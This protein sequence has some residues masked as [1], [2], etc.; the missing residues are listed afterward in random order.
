ML[1]R[2]FFFYVFFGQDFAYCD[3]VLG[4]VM[5]LLAEKGF[6]VDFCVNMSLG[7]SGERDDGEW[8]VCGKV[9]VNYHSFV[10]CWCIFFF[11][12]CNWLCS[13][14]IYLVWELE[15]WQEYCCEEL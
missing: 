6:K 11:F 9:S 5:E 14:F 8:D 2:C 3:E 15:G 12:F 13:D 4:N 7:G 1:F 10:F